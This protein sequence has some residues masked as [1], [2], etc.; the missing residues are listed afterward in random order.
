MLFGLGR[1]EDIAKLVMM[2]RLIEIGQK[3][4]IRHGSFTFT[5][6]LK[7]EPKV[8]ITWTGKWSSATSVSGTTR[9]KQASC[10]SSL[11]RW[12]AKWIGP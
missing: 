12:R 9:L 10:T 11:I 6:R 5:G 3:I 4:P 2:R 8:T 7:Y 1:E